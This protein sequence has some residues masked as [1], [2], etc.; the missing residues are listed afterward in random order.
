MI[1]C[2]TKACQS[3]FVVD[4]EDHV[5]GGYQ[6]ESLS[7]AAALAGYGVG[8]SLNELSYVCVTYTKGC[9]ELFNFS[10]SVDDL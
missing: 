4:R 7:A 1:F 2:L 9:L 8:F 6:C 5:D 3:T 10:A